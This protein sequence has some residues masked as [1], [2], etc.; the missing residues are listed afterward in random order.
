MTARLNSM[1][2]NLHG[3]TMH[4]YWRTAFQNSGGAF[5][6]S[7]SSDDAWADLLTRCASLKW[8]FIDEVETCDI[9]LLAQVEQKQI[10]CS[11]RQDM[12]AR[13]GGDSQSAKRPWG[14]VNVVMTGDWWQLTPTGGVAVMSNPVKHQKNHIMSRYTESNSFALQEWKPGVR[15]MELSKNI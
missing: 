2:D 14:G 10:A 6:N 13:E 9:E 7:M 1:A 8:I 3:V 5:V 11:A 15:V 4:K 12:F